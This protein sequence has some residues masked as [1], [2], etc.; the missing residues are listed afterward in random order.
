MD[1]PLSVAVAVVPRDGE[2]LMIERNRGDYTGYWAL[3]GGKIEQGEHVSEAAEREIMEET[4]LEASFR[5]YHGVVSEVFG[6]KQFML[7]VVGLEPSGSELSAGAEGEVRW[8][9]QDDLEELEVVPSDR[10]IISKVLD[11]PRNYFECMMIE[12]KE[13]HRLQSFESR[14]RGFQD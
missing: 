7:H 3:P 11:S 5:R 2:I 4:G 10:E 13:G 8:I 6:E 1:K 9:S 14:G 12:E